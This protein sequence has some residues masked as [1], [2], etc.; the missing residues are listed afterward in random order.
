MRFRSKTASF[1]NRVKQRVGENW[2]PNRP[3]I[4]RDPEGRIY[5]YK[6]RYTM[7]SVTLDPQG[8]L[9]GVTIEKSC[10]VDFLDQEAVAAFTR[11]QPFPNPPP[12]L[13]GAQ[14]DVRFT[15]GFY[16]EVN[17][18]SGFKVFRARD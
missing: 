13:V 4:Q 7:L 12:G 8:R 2:N 6:D 3:L 9:V 16:L 1:F 10:G 17:S 5:A 18:G 11:A 14:G 15:F